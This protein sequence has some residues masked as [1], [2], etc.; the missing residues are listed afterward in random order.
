MNFWSDQKTISEFTGSNYNY[1][2]AWLVVKYL[3]CRKN[4]GPFVFQ[5]C[6]YFP[7]NF[8]VDEIGRDKGITRRPFSFL[9]NRLR[10]GLRFDFKFKFS[11]KLM[12]SARVSPMSRRVSSIRHDSSKSASSGGEKLVTLIF[13]CWVWVGF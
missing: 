4:T 2:I 9:I 11:L 13:G 1:S 12:L 10:G 8:R 7:F 6:D 3:H 5:Q